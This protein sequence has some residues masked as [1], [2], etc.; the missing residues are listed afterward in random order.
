MR[1]QT[2]SCIELKNVN[3]E[4]HST[5]SLDFLLPL[6]HSKPCHVKKV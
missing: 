6:N 2:R 3:I 4:I 5:S 1:V